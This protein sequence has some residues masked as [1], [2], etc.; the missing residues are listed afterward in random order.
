MCVRFRA[1]H[2]IIK[3]P[4]FFSLLSTVRTVLRKWLLSLLLLQL[5]AVKPLYNAEEYARWARS[6]LCVW[7]L[8]YYIADEKTSRKVCVCVCVLNVKFSLFWLTYRSV[9]TRFDHHH[10]S[11]SP[12]KLWTV[13]LWSY[14]VI[15]F[16]NLFY[17]FVFAI[18]PSQS[19]L[20]LNYTLE[21]IWVVVIF[22]FFLS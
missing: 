16:F 13:T 15:M 2:R 9:G 7:I 11:N 22:F 21:M 5:I 4:F 10:T 18:S 6:M 12:N 19:L 8:S 1:I 14:T 20:Q 17:C 3:R